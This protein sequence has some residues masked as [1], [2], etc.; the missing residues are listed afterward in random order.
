VLEYLASDLSLF[1]IDL[2]TF[3]DRHYRE[4]GGTLEAV[5]RTIRDAHARGMW[6]EV[7]TLVVPGFNDSPDE[8]RDIAR[9]LVSVSPDIPWHVTAFHADYKMADR[10][11]T[12]A[13]QLLRAAEIGTEQGLRFVYAGNLPGLTGGWE[14]TRCP[15]CRAAVVRRRGFHILENRLDQGRCP[16]CA[17]VLPGVW[18]VPAEP[19]PRR[20]T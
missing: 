15:A 8:L 11:A 16:D 9:F 4:L 14:D 1:K 12:S 20:L 10:E 19:R 13:A 6:V 7:V 2:K 5:L 3:Q 17:H 18:G